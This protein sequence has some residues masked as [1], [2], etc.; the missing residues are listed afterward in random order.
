M[1]ERQKKTYMR[2]RVDPLVPM[3]KTTRWRRKRLADKGKNLQKQS[4]THAEMDT[5]EI[6]TEE[7]VKDTNDLY[8]NAPNVASASRS[9]EASTCGS[10]STEVI[11]GSAATNTSNSNRHHSSGGDSCGNLPVESPDSESLVSRQPT[12]AESMEKNTTCED[13][14]SAGTW[15]FKTV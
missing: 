2:Y 14:L 3:P 13:K 11:E 9:T 7:M 10:G 4:G 12:R 6:Y 1:A 8:N 5:T 15:L